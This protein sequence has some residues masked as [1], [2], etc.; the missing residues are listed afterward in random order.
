MVRSLRFFRG[1]R[2]LVF[3]RCILHGWMVPAMT[4]EANVPLINHQLFKSH[5]G[6]C[7]N[8]I[9]TYIYHK[10]QPNVA[11]YANHGFYGYMCVS[12]SHP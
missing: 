12:F 10:N 3:L 5:D 4:D 1:L 9:F 7:G 8:V 2:V 6:L 11:K